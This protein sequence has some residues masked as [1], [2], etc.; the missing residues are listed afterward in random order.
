MRRGYI[1]RNGDSVRTGS[2]GGNRSGVSGTERIR[3][4]GERSLG[5]LSDSGGL[6]MVLPEIRVLVVL[7]VLRILGLLRVVLITVDI[8]DLSRARALVGHVTR[9]PAPETSSNPGKVLTLLRC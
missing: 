4:G 7:G 1:G 8:G 3:S 5:N 9:L 6:M 2:R